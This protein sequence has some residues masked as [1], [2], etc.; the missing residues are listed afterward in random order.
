MTY[1]IKI[2]DNTTTGKRIINNLRKH[3]ET[4]EF[5]ETLSSKNIHE[6]YYS[7]EEFR[8]IAI[9]KGQIFCDK[10]GII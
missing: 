10:H 2:D 5:V 1:I 6:G 3:P 9:D 4:V 8:K 7:L